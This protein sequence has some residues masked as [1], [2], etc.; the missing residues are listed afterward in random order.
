DFVHLDTH[1]VDHADDVFDL[2]RIDDVVGQVVVDFG[3]GQ[4]A[5]FQALADQQLDIGLLGR[6][7]V[8][9]VCLRH[10]IGEWGT[11]HY[12]APL[13]IWPYFAA[14]RTAAHASA[15]VSE[16]TPPGR[17]PHSGFK[18]ATGRS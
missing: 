5:L 13:G 8:G 2:F 17:D 15:G 3:K 4:V 10:R 11:Q 9:H 12:T 7:F 6:T 14:E 1:A 16:P 18:A